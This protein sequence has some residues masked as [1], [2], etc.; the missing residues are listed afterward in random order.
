MLNFEKPFGSSF[1]FA[2]KISIYYDEKVLGMV[3]TVDASS[4]IEA[5]VLCHNLLS[6]TEKGSIEE[7]VGRLYLDC[8]GDNMLQLRAMFAEKTWYRFDLDDTLH[9]FRRSLGTATNDDLT[10]FPNGITHG[11]R[12]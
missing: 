1:V 4:L 6:N 10:K 3:A 5:G 9:E 8:W 12:H 2:R 7:H 11:W